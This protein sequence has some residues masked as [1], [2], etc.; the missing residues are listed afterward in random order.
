VQER[1]RYTAYGVVTFLNADFTTKNASDFDWE[2][3]YAGYRWD[4]ESG[5]YQVRWRYLNPGLGVWMT[6]DPLG[7]LDGL[8]RYPFVLSN[9]ITNMDASGALTITATS[10]NLKVKCGDTAVQTVS[11]TLDDVAPFKGYL[12]QQ[13][14]VRCNVNQ[15]G[16]CPD[17][18]P[19]MADFSYWEAWPVSQFDTTYKSIR[20]LSYTDRFARPITK[21]TCGVVSVI[22]TVTFF[23]Y[24]TTGL[25][26]WPKAR[27]YGT[28][29]CRWSA[30]SLPST[31]IQPSWWDGQAIEGPA[32]HYLGAGWNC[33]SAC[34]G[35]TASAFAYP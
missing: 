31:D 26:T 10:A 30:Q 7:H 35:N 27:V 5:L 33:C 25:I 17:S 29:D 21:D 19:A 8:S 18:S 23:L 14:D 22:G 15:C 12:V 2:T 24:V 3:L 34:G 4:A 13:V 20:G 6:R 16:D 28:G 9:P 1:Y 32:L 11:F